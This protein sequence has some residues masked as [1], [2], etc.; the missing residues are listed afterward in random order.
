MPSSLWSCRRLSFENMGVASA[1]GAGSLAQSRCLVS[2]WAQ[3]RWQDSSRRIAKAP[4]RQD[5][6][7]FPKAGFGVFWKSEA[8]K[9]KSSLVSIRCVVCLPWEPS[10]GERHLQMIE[11]QGLA[12]YDI[13]LTWKAPEHSYTLSLQEQLGYANSRKKER[14]PTSPKI[15][16]KMTA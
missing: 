12:R 10:W 9:Q 5:S 2:I 11:G 6:L 3:W 1:E 13:S 7:H 16:W 15:F 14:H 4:T 8:G